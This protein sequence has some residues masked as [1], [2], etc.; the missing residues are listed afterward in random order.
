[1]H[2]QVLQY[3]QSDVTVGGKSALAVVLNDVTKLT[4]PIPHI[5]KAITAGK[6]GQTTLSKDFLQPGERSVVVRRGPKSKH[7]RCDTL[8]TDSICAETWDKLLQREC[9]VYK[10]YA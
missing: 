2:M 4:Y 9:T 1:M 5:K 10:F 8:Y 3:M 7:R 6:Y